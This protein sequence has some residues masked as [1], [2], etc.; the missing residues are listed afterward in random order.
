ML[1]FTV[2]NYGWFCFALTELRAQSSQLA[3]QPPAQ[4]NIELMTGNA[5]LAAKRLLVNWHRKYCS[6]DDIVDVTT[7]LLGPGER[8][9]QMCAVIETLKGGHTCA[10]RHPPLRPCSQGGVGMTA[11][12]TVYATLILRRGTALPCRRRVRVA[13]GDLR[14]AAGACLRHAGPRSPAALH[15]DNAR[16]GRAHG[17]PGVKVRATLRCPCPVICWHDLLW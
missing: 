15:R 17:A 11:W 8:V 1:A 6:A 4:S 5:D 7:R 14:G 13:P 9:G 10:R 12:F 16:A 2:E 3:K